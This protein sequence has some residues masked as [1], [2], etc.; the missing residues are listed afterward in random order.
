MRDPEAFC[1]SILKGVLDRNGGHWNPSDEEDVLQDMRILLLRLAERYDRNRTRMVFS[2]YATWI[3]QRRFGVDIY[4]TKLVDRRYNTT[5][6]PDMSLDEL[7]ERLDH[8]IMREEA[9]ET[10]SREQSDLLT[11]F[12]CAMAVNDLSALETHEG[13]VSYLKPQEANA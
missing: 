3:L 7:R 6:T 13:W 12:A 5:R 9:D 4:R 2:T 8:S 1:R 11:R 10:P